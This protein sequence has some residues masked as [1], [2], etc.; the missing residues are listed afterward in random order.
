MALFETQLLFQNLFSMIM[1]GRVGLEFRLHWVD[2]I[3]QL[4]PL[5]SNYWMITQNYHLKALTKM[6]FLLIFRFGAE[7]TKE[8]ECWLCG[9]HL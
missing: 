6:G 4:L 9:Y 2:Y 1:G 3:Q 7:A 8:E 5:S